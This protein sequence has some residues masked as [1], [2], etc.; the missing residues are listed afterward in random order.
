MGRQQFKPHL[1]L[2]SSYVNGITFSC[3]KM[4]VTERPDPRNQEETLFQLILPAAHKEVALKWCHD[5]VGHLGLECKLDL[6]HD[7]FFCP[8]MAAQVKEHIERCHSCINFKA[9]QPK[10]PL[11]N[12]MA[13]HPLQLV[14]F[15]YL[16]LK[17]GKGLEENVLVIMDHFIQ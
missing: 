1:S 3:K 6:M 16:C 5:E 7:Q 11:E 17:P 10:V 14:H 8:H 15:D 12:I 4:F 2:I 9:K 13:T